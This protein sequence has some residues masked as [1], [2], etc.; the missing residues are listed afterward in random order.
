MFSLCEVSDV[1]STYNEL[2]TNPSYGLSHKPVSP[3]GKQAIHFNVQDR[4]KC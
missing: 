2:K 1:L 3:Q 4:I